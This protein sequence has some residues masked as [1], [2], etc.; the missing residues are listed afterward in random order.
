MVPL[1]KMID[2]LVEQF[3]ASP[4]VKAAAKRNAERVAFK[5]L[6]SLGPTKA[7]IASVAEEFLKLGRSL[8]EVSLCIS[9][10]HPRMG[11]LRDL[12]LEVYPTSGE[13]TVLV[14]GRTR[15]AK[16]H[17]CGLYLQLRIPLFVSDGDAVVTL[18]DARLT[19]G[20][21]PKR[22]KPAGPSRFVVEA[23]DRSF[24]LFKVLEEATLC[25]RLLGAT[26]VEL[27]VVAALRRYS[28]SKLPVTERLLRETGFLQRVSADYARRYPLKLADGRGRSP[29]KLAEEALVEAC[30]SII[31]RMLGDLLVR[32]YHLRPSAMRSLIVK[33]ELADLK[34]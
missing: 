32:K 17:R 27:E 5:L 4:V 26:G 1:R 23:D 22:I 28:V 16:A 24:Q 34:G 18:V 10:I 33:T 11:Q 19:R 14:N 9:R 3:N 2:M 6:D 12:V 8:A 30:E 29:K 25:G 15:R 20:Y 31:P 7:A 21:D 13:V